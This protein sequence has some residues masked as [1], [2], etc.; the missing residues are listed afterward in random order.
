MAKKGLIGLESFTSSDDY[1]GMEWDEEG[2]PIES[3]GEEPQDDDNNKPAE[4]NQSNDDGYSESVG[5]GNSDDDSSQGSGESTR[6][7]GSGSSPNKYTAFARQLAEE[8][9]FDASDDEINNVTDIDSWNN[10]LK[11]KALARMDGYTKFMAEYVRDGA[12]N[13]QKQQMQYMLDMYSQVSGI[14]EEDVR[15]EK[16]EDIRRGIIEQDF[17]NRGFTP[18][19]AKKQAQRSFDSGDDVDDALTALKSLQSYYG[20]NINQMKEQAKK[21]RELQERAYRERTDKLHDSIINGK[22]SFGGIDVDKKMRKDIWEAI[23]KPVAVDKNDNTYNA[24]QKFMSE[25]YDEAIKLLAYA[26]VTTDYGKN[27]DKLVKTSAKKEVNRAR[28]EMM[29]LIEGR[30]ADNGNGMHIVGVG[31]PEGK[32]KVGIALDVD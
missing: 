4:D 11:E 3:S 16:S 5:E 7:Q 22:D 18:E 17:L 6:P 12:N 31:S 14:K 28:T 8:G 13:E 10:F 15:D 19:Q 21:Q 20:G 30:G 2:N 24:I 1:E 26:C 32:R 29:D 27:W 9:A 25:N 23:S